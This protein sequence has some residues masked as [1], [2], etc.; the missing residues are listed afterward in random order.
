MQKPI[1]QEMLEAVTR[2]LGSD[3]AKDED[4]FSSHPDAEVRIRTCTE[5]E[6]LGGGMSPSENLETHVLKLSNGSLV[7]IVAEK[8]SEA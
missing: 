8:I 6:L 4:W 3:S 5:D 1:N 2:I 7:R